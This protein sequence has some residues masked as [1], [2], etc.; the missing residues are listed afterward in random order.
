MTTQIIQQEWLTLDEVTGV[1]RQR[2]VCLLARDLLRHALHGNL[3]LSVWFQSQVQLRPLEPESHLV[4][5]TEDGEDC[6]QH[7]TPPYSL[8]IRP[9]PDMRR[10][11]MSIWDL[12]LV[13]LERRLIQRQLAE[14][15]GVNGSEHAY[16]CSDVGIVVS[17]L[18]GQHYQLCDRKPLRDI[19]LERIRRDGKLPDAFHRI[20]SRLYNCRFASREARLNIP[21]W[22]L[23][24]VLPRDAVLVI[25]RSQLETLLRRYQPE[26]SPR[27]SSPSAHL[28]WLACKKHP[29][30]SDELLSH[31]YKLINIFESWAREEGLAI[32]VNGDTI[33][34]MLERGAP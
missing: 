18:S 6:F 10:T 19:A 31:P 16:C 21:F 1:M 30:L 2:D 14:S 28:F 12:P 9:H 29:L 17:D 26:R 34:R 27:I 4:C 24:D 15:L 13:G 20:F 32:Q 25:R 22:Y 33:K 5:R 7:N 8:L 3:T 23:P 11:R